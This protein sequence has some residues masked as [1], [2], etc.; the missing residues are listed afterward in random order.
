MPLE[1]GHCLV[2][3]RAPPPELADLATPRL[4]PSPHPPSHH[5]YRTDVSQLSAGVED[6]R[7]TAG[8]AAPQA[9]NGASPDTDG[10][11]PT[12][13]SRRRRDYSTDGF[14][15][16][17]GYGW[18]TAHARRAGGA[19]LHGD[20]EDFLHLCHR[21]VAAT[22]AP[23]LRARR[24]L[25]IRSA[26]LAC[27]TTATPG[28]KYHHHHHHQHPACHQWRCLVIKTKHMVWK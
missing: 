19:V 21:Y 7:L 2:P 16:Q 23:W 12:L 18:S 14:Q 5:G 8:T 22:M 3:S 1:K 26:P 10:L 9:E 28:V 17:Y 6:T 24:P 27:H 4:P 11:W 25:P 20:G 13:A 15:Q